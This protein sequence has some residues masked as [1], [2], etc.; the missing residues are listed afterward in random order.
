[1]NVHRF[2]ARNK[3]RR[4]SPAKYFRIEWPAGGNSPDFM[5][6]AAIFQEIRDTL[7]LCDARAISASDA[8]RR[9]GILT[10]LYIRGHDGL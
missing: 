6:R 1:M 2:P 10:Q 7:A 5:D 4:H 3:E 9:V 8:E